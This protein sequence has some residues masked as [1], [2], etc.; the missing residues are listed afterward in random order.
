MLPACSCLQLG[1][2]FL[3]FSAQDLWPLG[4]LPRW[5]RCPCCFSYAWHGESSRIDV[6]DRCGHSSLLLVLLELFEVPLERQV[7]HAA[8]QDSLLNGNRSLQTGRLGVL[9]FLGT[10]VSQPRPT[11]ILGTSRQMTLARICR[12]L[13]VSIGFLFTHP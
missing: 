7:G 10:F 12:V 9:D 3:R 4:Y 1:A 13:W 11:R 6:W 2:F 8:R 5:A